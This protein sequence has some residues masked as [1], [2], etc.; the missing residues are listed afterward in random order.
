MPNLSQVREVQIHHLNEH[1]KIISV[2]LSL[3]LLCQRG[4]G[5]FEEEN[6]FGRSYR[7]RLSHLVR[8][9]REESFLRR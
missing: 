9:I 8:K 3:H 2:P 4:R 1:V 5:I 7:L 6:A